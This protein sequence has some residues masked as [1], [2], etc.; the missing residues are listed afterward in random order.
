M[1]QKH[2]RKNRKPFNPEREKVKFYKHLTAFIIVNTVFSLITFFDGQGFEWF[3]VM[4]FWGIGLAFHY[5]KAFGIP[6]MNGKGSKAWEMEML[7]KN[8]EELLEETPLDLNQR[9]EL[10]EKQ[11]QKQDT[12]SDNDL[13]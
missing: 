12:W 8:E 10:R 3:N 2:R 11:A 13:V 4:G 5:V 1:G 6:F 7:G 9:P